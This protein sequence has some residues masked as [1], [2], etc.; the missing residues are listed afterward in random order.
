MKCKGFC[1]YKL[2]VLMTTCCTVN[3]KNNVFTSKRKDTGDIEICF[4]IKCGALDFLFKYK[5][6]QTTTK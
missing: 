3:I 4:C 2:H 5:Q 6:K 1:Q